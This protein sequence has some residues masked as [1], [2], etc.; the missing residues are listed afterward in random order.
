[1]QSVKTKFRNQ[2]RSLDYLMLRDNARRMRRVPTEAERILWQVVRE[3]RFGVKFRRQHIIGD[4]IA[5]FASITAG[6]II[7]IDGGY[8]NEPEQRA[9]DAVRT[10]YLNECGFKVLRFTNEQIIKNI[11]YVIERIER[12]LR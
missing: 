8:H 11:D 2:K 5:D 3:N 10:Q 7:E 4:Y 9:F 6:L 1:M 12:E